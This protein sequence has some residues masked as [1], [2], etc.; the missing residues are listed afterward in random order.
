VK[1]RPIDLANYFDN[2]M[3]LKEKLQKLVGREIDLVEEQT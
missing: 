1:F 2:Y 3:A